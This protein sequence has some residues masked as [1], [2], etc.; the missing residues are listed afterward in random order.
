MK[1]SWVFIAAIVGLLTIGTTGGVI[2]AQEDTADDG[3][4]LK[5]LVSRVAAILGIDEG[6]VQAAFD[7][8]QEEMRDEALERKLAALVEQGRL[9]E[10]QADEYREWYQSRPEGIAPGMSFGKRGGHG[11]FGRGMRLGR[12][13]HGIGSGAPVAPPPAAAAS[14]S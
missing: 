5:G 8:A 10:E 11:F 2:L 4:P 13:G 1:K 6:D 3:S 9:T 12:R 14:M 7:Q